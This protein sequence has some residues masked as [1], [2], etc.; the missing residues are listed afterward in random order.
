LINQNSSNT[1]NWFLIVG[2]TDNYHIFV[3]ADGL[4]SNLTYITQN[5]SIGWVEFGH[6]LISV[7]QFFEH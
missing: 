3:M 4:Y 7:C 2:E 6:F 5:T 1:S